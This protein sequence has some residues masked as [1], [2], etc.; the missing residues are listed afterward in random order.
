MSLLQSWRRSGHRAACALLGAAALGGAACGGDTPK[1]EIAANE[2]PLTSASTILDEATSTTAG[3][4]ATT[5]TTGR[6]GTTARKPRPVPGPPNPAFFGNG[7]DYY[8]KLKGPRPE[9]VRVAH[10]GPRLSR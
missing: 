5:A 4:L 9:E 10:P 3:A 8:N 6:P 1:T 2:P 7:I